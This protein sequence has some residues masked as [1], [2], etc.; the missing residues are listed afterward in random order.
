M[1]RVPVVNAQGGLEGVL[2]VDDIPELLAGQMSGLAGLIRVEQQRERE[3]R[4]GS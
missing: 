2:T 1:H 4:T 3:R